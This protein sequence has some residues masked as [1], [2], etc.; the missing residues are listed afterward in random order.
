MKRLL[1]MLPAALLLTGC[2]GD[3]WT[4]SLHD[5]LQDATRLRVLPG[6]MHPL[7]INAPETV[8]L[9]LD[10]PAEVARVVQAIHIDAD[11][12]GFACG[13][14]G[15]FRPEFY[16]DETL[17][18]TLTYH[19][20]RSLR[21]DDWEEGDGLLTDEAQAF[22]NAWLDRHGVSVPEVEDPFGQPHPTPASSSAA[23]PAPTDEH[24]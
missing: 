17:L 11:E 4:D 8:L 13:C 6:A 20:G 16:R 12:S 19:H 7:S 23:E 22:L 24:R 1:I 18:E 3:D 5:A 10:D 9:D 15:E 2:R 14:G 21:W